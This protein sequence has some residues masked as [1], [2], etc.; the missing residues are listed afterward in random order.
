[1]DLF[2]LVPIFGIIA[3]IYTFLQSSWVSKQDAG[4]DRMKE[5]AGYISDGAMAFL[6]AEYKV[7]AYFV[8]VVAILLIAQRPAVAPEIATITQLAG[9]HL[10]EVFLTASSVIKLF[11]S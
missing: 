7:M 5:I 6:K 1:M 11:I 9:I 2:Y 4:N 10:A 3:L 8:V